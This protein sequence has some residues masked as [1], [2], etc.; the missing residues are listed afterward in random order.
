MVSIFALW[1]PI[2]IAAVLVWVVSALFWT[3]SPHRK[4]DWKGVADEDALRDALRGQN[5]APGQYMVPFATGGAA[6]EPAHQQK[7]KEGP[8]AL[9]T[10]ARP[11]FGTSMATP[12]ILT[13]VYYIVVGIVVAYITGRTMS[14]GDEYLAVFRVAG[15][16]AWLAYGFGGIADSIW[17]ARPWS[18]TA[19]TVVEAL[20]YGLLTAGAFAGFWPEA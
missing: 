1:L 8:V 4:Q 13:L 15:T 12:M 14:P 3:V 9:I 7:M 16:A 19:N 2:L 11:G 6:R 10:V 18:S 20:I 5:L 17:F